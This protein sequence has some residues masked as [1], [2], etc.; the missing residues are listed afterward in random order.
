MYNNELFQEIA[1]NPGITVLE[2]AEHF[3]QSKYAIR[4]KL[5]LLEK[6]DVLYTRQEPS[7]NTRG[8]STVKTYYPQQTA[9][10]Y[11]R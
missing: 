2:L 11:K 6:Y 1:S 3:G 4:R 8:K 10:K 9:L 7:P 5:S